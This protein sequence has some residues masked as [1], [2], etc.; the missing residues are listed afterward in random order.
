MI[1][2]DTVFP[3]WRYGSNQ[4][5]FLHGKRKCEEGNTVSIEQFAAGKSLLNFIS[6]R[7]WWRRPPP[8]LGWGTL[9]WPQRSTV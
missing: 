3:Y 5:S 9:F 2:D 7:A 8:A 4:P 6:C 1:R